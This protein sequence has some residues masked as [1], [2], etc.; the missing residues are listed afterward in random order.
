MTDERLRQADVGDELGDA[1]LAL[2]QATDDAQAVH[3]GEGLVEGTQL[4]QV[5][6]LGDDL[7]RSWS[8]PGRAMG[9]GAMD[10]GVWMARRGAST[11]IDINRTLML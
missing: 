9:T 7:R 2:G 5:V 4:A 8:G 1:R 6:G 11:T 10:S 3:V